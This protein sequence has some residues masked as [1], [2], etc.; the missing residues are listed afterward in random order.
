MF[1]RSYQQ[2]YKSDDEQNSNYRS[3]SKAAAKE[4]ITNLIDAQRY[5]I[6][7]QCLRK[8]GMRRTPC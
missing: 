1:I 4:Q 3:D 5:D 8:S 6:S 2:I 7:K